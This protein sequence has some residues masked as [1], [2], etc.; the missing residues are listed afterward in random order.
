MSYVADMTD[1]RRARGEARRR[2]LIEA[3]LRVVERAGVAGLSHRAVAEE[4]GVSVAS[5]GYHF[6]GMDE[7]VATALAHATDELAREVSDLDPTISALARF[8]ADGGELRG[9]LIVGYELYLLA[10]RNP[11]ARPGTLEWLD[12]VADRLAPELEGAARYAFQA[13]LEGICLHMLL[14]DEPYEAEAIEAMI[15]LAWPGRRDEAV[16]R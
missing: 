12:F 5:A 8:L 9:R 2:Q 15:K 11:G 7:L 14:R 6:A 13:T 16:L 3:T 4:A 10:V 1:G